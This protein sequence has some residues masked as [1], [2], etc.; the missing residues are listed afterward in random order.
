MPG[1]LHWS[2]RCGHVTLDIARGS[3]LRGVCYCKHCQAFARHLDAAEDLDPAGGTEIYQTTPDLIHVTQGHDRFACLRLTSQGPLRWFT[4][5]CHTPIANTATTRQ[6]PF[7]SLMLAHVTDPD[8][9]GKI[10]A[11]VNP[12]GATGKLPGK[13]R[14]MG[15]MVL[16]V[17][18]RGLTARLAG[19]HH[20]TPFFREDGLPVADPERLTPEERS[21]AYGP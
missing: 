8:A 16:G 5:C 3:G 4:A 17:I 10:R 14:G 12:D 20:E 7:A 19:K 11:R 15:A 1:P 6:V 9:A 2:C 21:K 13:A 18:G